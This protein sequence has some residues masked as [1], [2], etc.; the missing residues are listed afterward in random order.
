MTDNQ[1][2][3]IRHAIRIMDEELHTM[4]G[5]MSVA[6]NYEGYTNQQELDAAIAHRMQIINSLRTMIQETT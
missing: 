4:R 5:G 1:R 3:V 6:Y 2:E